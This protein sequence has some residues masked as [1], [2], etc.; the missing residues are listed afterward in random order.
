MKRFLPPLLLLALLAASAA[1]Y[2]VLVVRTPPAHAPVAVRVEPLIEAA[3]L[4]M[5]GLNL[6]QGEKG[7]EFWRLK[8]DW[9]AM[10]Q[11]SGVIDVREP[12]VRYTLGDGSKEDYV[13]VVSQ[14]GKITDDQRVLTMWD[15]VV[16]THGQDVLTGPLLVYKTD[17]RIARFPDGA[18]FENPGMDGAFGNLQWNMD[19][20]LL[21]GGNGVVVVFKARDATPAAHNAAGTTE[22]AIP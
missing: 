16:M 8:A 9:A 19:T 6:M 7:L 4:A 1:A 22:P 10:H 20:N 14:L 21:D 15:H 11:D 2:Y 17:E 12:R 13:F 5:K 18:E 3:A